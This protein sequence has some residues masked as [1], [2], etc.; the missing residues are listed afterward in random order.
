MLMQRLRDAGNL[1]GTRAKCC[2][3]HP[4]GRFLKRERLKERKPT[5]R[6]QRR[7]HSAGRW[8]RAETRAYRMR[9]E[10]RA[11]AGDRDCLAGLRPAD[12]WT[13]AE[14]RALARCPISSKN[15]C[16]KGST[17]DRDCLAGQKTAGIGRTED[18]LPECLRIVAHLRRIGVFTESELRLQF[19]RSREAWLSGIL[20]DLD[21]RNVYDYLKGMVNCHRMHLFDV[22]NQYRAIFSNDKSGNEENYDGGLL[23]S[24]SMHQIRNHLATLE[25]M[26]PKISEG[27]LLSNI[28]DQCM[29]CAMGLGLVGV[30]FRGLLPPLFEE[31]LSSFH[32]F[33]NLFSK[34]MSTAVENFQVVL[35]SHRWVP[36]PS[37]GFAVS[38]TNEESLDDVTPP[39]FL[40]EHPPIAV[41]V[42]G[43]GILVFSALMSL[44]T[45]KLKGEIFVVSNHRG[46]V[47]VIMQ[48]SM[49]SLGVSAAMNDLRPCAPVSLKHILADE[50]VNGLQAVS[51]SLLQYSAVQ[52]LRGSESPLFLSLC[53][54]FIEVAYPYCATCFGRC[55]PNGAALIME[56]MGMFNSIN[57]LF[58]V[59]PIRA[60][61]K[62]SDNADKV[63]VAENGDVVVRQRAATVVDGE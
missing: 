6:E 38:G 41:F 2:P 18:R 8:T 50:L 62:S 49:R 1:R 20:D 37:V 10:T 35:D 51:N 13:R 39:S 33:I 46:K 9:A 44:L 58:I 59:S 25:I 31:Y 5:R 60:L 11:L 28:L 43:M 53:Q 45:N 47:A 22:V 19:L 17:R 26:L 14:T 48:S 55:Y 29:Y 27:G 52:V 56:R 61:K 23:F 15:A 40:M 16:E 12:Y 42:N 36:L 57:Q 30:D 34:N 63:T 7:G 54:A 4:G 3:R 32:L 24:W 21:Q